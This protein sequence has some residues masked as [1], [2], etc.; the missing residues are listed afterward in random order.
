MTALASLI[1]LPML[2]GQGAPLITLKLEKLAPELR[3][4]AMV[5]APTGTRVLLTLEDK[6]VRIIDAATRT[7]V[8]KLTSHPDF[9]YAAAW[10][11]DGK[12]VAVGDDSA[13]IYIEDPATGVKIRE[14]RTHKR[15]IQKLSFSQSGNLLLSTGNDDSMNIYDLASIEVE[16][17]QNILGKGA[18]FYGGA[19]NPKSDTSIAVGILG[20]AGR[21]YHAGTGQ[22]K[23]FLSYAGAEGS[24]DVSFNPNGT[25]MATAGRDGTASVWDTKNNKKIATLMGHKDWVVKTLYSANGRLLAT[26][27]NDLTVKVWDTLTYK[28]VADIPLQSGVGSPMAFTADGRFFLAVDQSGALQVF[29]ITPPQPTVKAVTKAKS[30]PKK[31]RRKRT[32]R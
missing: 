26:S 2:G 9:P 31:K 24:Y 32:P 5:A 18:N 19:F 11:Q 23:S 21:V 14:Y 30:T 28:K 22:I 27:S 10:S 8:R 13:R 3:P 15:G 1:F 29:K 17:L 16:E 12:R 25:R 20:D 4:L 6:S 7:T